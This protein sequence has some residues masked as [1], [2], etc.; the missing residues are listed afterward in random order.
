MSGTLSTPELLRAAR[1]G[2][3]HSCEQV[4]RENAG[5]IWSI[6]RR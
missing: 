6:V 5:L 1:E 4:L 3:E 2:D